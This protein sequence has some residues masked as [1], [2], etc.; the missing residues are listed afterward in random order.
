MTLLNGHPHLTKSR[1][2]K[3]S[4]DGLDELVDAGVVGAC[5]VDR[6]SP[7]GG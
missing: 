5:K 2:A 6:G 1:P 3:R 7:G 4:K